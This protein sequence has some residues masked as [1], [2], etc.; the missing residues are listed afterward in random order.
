MEVEEI[1]ETDSRR[2]LWPLRTLSKTA[3]EKDLSS[4]GPE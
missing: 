2:Y 1:K 3:D 4:K